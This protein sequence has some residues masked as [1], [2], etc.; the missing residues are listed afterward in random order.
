MKTF[1]IGL[2]DKLVLIK[3][4]ISGYDFKECLYEKQPTRLAFDPLKPNL[5]YC[6]T[7]NDGL[8]RSENNGK[9]WEKIGESHLSSERNINGG[10]PSSK[11]TS[12]AVSPVRNVEGN[13]VIYA[14]TEPS[15]LF[16]SEDRGRTFQEFKGIQTLPSK[17]DWAF[18]PRPYTHFV[19][20]I[21]PSY[22]KKDHLAISIEAGAVL[23]T[24]DHGETWMDRP[25]KSPIDV[26]TLLTHPK[27][28][29]RLYAANGDGAS[30]KERAYAESADEGRNWKY[31]SEGLEEHPY[32]YNMVL[33][34]ENPNDRIVSAS[35]NA[36]AAHGARRYSTVYRKIGEEPWRELA[37]GLP[38]VQA[39][40]HHLANDPDKTGAFYAFNNYGIY[41]LA[42]G[43][44]VWEKTSIPW[45]AYKNQRA[46]CFAV[47]SS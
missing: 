33:H 34:P 12:V 1:Y 21:T 11:I 27:T 36:S 2:K 6:S 44:K 40:T 13:S 24:T 41:Y 46:Y 15:M 20:W 43:K 28:P 22:S 42:D 23:R 17:K 16:Y 8:W 19:R 38:R 45:E 5:I 9:H 14:G 3:E 31:M 35:K 25:E 29:E 4:T 37:K 30:N 7:R 18:P 39:Y 47:Q 10:L 32:L 26:H